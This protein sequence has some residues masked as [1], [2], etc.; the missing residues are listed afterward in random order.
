VNAYKDSNV[1]TVGETEDFIDFGGIIAFVRENDKI[2]FDINRE[3]AKRAEI[4]ISS[5]VLRLARKVLP[6]TRVENPAGKQMMN[7]MFAEYGIDYSK[8]L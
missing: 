5:R 2:L 1:L 8:L 7:K 4:E 3:A 6:G